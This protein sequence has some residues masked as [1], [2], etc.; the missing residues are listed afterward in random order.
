M[1]LSTHGKP[2]RLFLTL[3][4]AA[5]ISC[6]AGARA[7]TPGTTADADRG[8]SADK[9]IR[10]KWALVVGISK[11][12]NKSV[13]QLKYAAKD[14]KDFYRFLIN[15]CNFAPDHVRLLLYEKATE[16]RVMSE[17]GSK[18]LARLARNDDLVVLF[19]STHGSPS[20]LDLRGKSYLLAHDSDPE[21]LFATA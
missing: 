14:A 15:K 13:P 11:F 18:F 4:A 6:H 8:K 10:D 17:L 2:A 9:P 12:K 16:R 20:Q 7:E 19:F 21:D 1:L 5:A 3:L